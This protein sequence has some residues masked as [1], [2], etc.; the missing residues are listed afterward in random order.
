M[1]GSVNSLHFLPLLLVCAAAQAEELPDPTRPPAELSAPVADAARSVAEGDVLQS[2]ILA[3]GRRA[4]IINGQ[5]VR[6]G[7][8][9]GNAK[10]V[11]VGEGQAVLQGPQGRRVLSLFP[12]V[13]I[14]KNNAQETAGVGGTV[15]S[16]KKTGAD[17]KGAQ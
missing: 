6:V 3:A 8:R 14:R 4:A 17:Q 13:V 7:E 12:D 16:N 5:E 2:V 11:E 10:L 15:R 1:A 9:Y